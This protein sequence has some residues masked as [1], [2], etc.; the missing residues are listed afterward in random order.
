MIPSPWVP[1]QLAVVGF[2]KYADDTYN[3]GRDETIKIPQ[4]ITKITASFSATKNN[5]D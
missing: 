4:S 3:L 2:H 5:S 1:E